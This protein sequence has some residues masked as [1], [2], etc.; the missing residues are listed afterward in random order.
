MAI[1]WRCG[2]CKAAM[3]RRFEGRTTGF[4]W[5]VGEFLDLLGLSASAKYKETSSKTDAEK[6][7]DDKGD[8][9]SHHRW[10][11]GA[12]TRVVSDGES[13]DD[14]HCWNEGMGYD[15]INERNLYWV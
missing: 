15:W 5:E 10:S 3:I 1:V 6:D 9:K 11:H 14:G 7:E 12:A 13:G 2:D 4:E 8:K